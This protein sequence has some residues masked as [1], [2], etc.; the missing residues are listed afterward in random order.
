MLRSGTLGV[1]VRCFAFPLSGTPEH[2]EIKQELR[3]QIHLAR[4][5]P[6]LGIVAVLSDT[7]G[8]AF[9]FFDL[10]HRVSL[11]PGRLDVKVSETGFHTTLPMSWQL[12]LPYAPDAFSLTFFLIENA[13]RINGMAWIKILIRTIIDWFLEIPPN[14]L[15]RGVERFLDQAAERRR[16]KRKIRHRKVRRNRMPQEP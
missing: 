13:A 6:E 8:H 7:P 2:M 10:I 5:V 3:H 11:M 4:E 12:P 15:G 9:H 14:L 16:L 1:K